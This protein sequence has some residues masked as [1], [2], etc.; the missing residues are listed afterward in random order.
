MLLTPLY[1]ELV[2]DRHF[3]QPHFS[4]MTSHSGQASFMGLSRR[5]IWGYGIADLKFRLIALS[6]P[7]SQWKGYLLVPLIRLNQF[8]SLY[9]STEN[10]MGNSVRSGARRGLNIPLQSGPVCASVHT[11]LCLC[12]YAWA[13]IF[14][15][16]SCACKEWSCSWFFLNL[17]LQQTNW[18]QSS[19]ELSG[20]WHS[21]LLNS[22]EYNS[23]NSPADSASLCR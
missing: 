3:T 1:A 23:L 6:T 14:S 19:Q 16:L 7:L 10:F 9:C 20:Q 12:I 5:F 13:H 2:P 8:K 4:S 18:A 21:D 22:S 17:H 15:C 11:W